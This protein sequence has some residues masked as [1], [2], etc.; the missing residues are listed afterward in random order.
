MAATIVLVTDQIVKRQVRE[1][2]AFGETIH[3]MPGLDFV[4]TTNRGIAFSQ[5]PGHQ[6]IVA[7][8]TAIALCVI[9]V[10]L[11]RFGRRSAAVLIGG[12]MLVGGAIGNLIDRL[13]H[14]GVTDFIAVT[15]HWPPF[16]VADIGIVCG[17]IIAGI[18]L[19]G[20]RTD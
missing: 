14:D 20:E 3:V 8:L 12:G 15:S 6:R 11:V 2:I 18:G 13:S 1:H 17:A 19:M 10:A 16:N 9:A 5:F 4:H 7:S